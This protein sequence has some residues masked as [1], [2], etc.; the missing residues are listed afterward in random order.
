MLDLAQY[1]TGA[2]RVWFDL[3]SFSLKRPKA[4]SFVTSERKTFFFF[5]QSVSVDT[6]STFFRYLQRIS[7]S[8]A[9][10]LYSLYG[11][12]SHS[13]GMS[14]GHYIAYIRNR[15]PSLACERFF[16]EAAGLLDRGMKAVSC[17]IEAITK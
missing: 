15:P 7:D 14:S 2:A 17:K 9:K 16:Y 11:V 3:Q 4:P 6:L 13:G 1:C 5:F 10:V 8:E 12:V